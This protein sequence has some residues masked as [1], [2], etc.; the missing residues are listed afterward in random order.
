MSELTAYTNAFLKIVNKFRKKGERYISPVP[1]LTEE[2]GK[3]VLS[4]KLPAHGTYDTDMMWQCEKPI[5]KYASPRTAR[6]GLSQS[7]AN[8]LEKEQPIASV[9]PSLR[10]AVTCKL[11]N[12]FPSEKGKA[13][14]ACALQCPTTDGGPNH[15]KLAKL[16]DYCLGLIV[17]SELY[18]KATDAGELSVMCA[19]RVSNEALNTLGLAFGL[20][21]ALNVTNDTDLL[22]QKVIATTI[23]ALIGAAWQE[24]GE[25]GAKCVWKLLNVLS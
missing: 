25:K 18:D 13:A 15:G 14:M 9:V 10:D 2:D 3:Y 19:E 12:V 20:D 1:N 17:A 24:Y 6:K 23:E 8:Q 7:L 5:T 11:K 22:S 21:K 16:G 4:I